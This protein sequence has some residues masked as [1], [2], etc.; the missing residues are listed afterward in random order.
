MSTYEELSLIVSVALL[1]VAIL[2]IHI[3][4]SRPAPWK[5]IRTAVSA[6]Y[7]SAGSGDMRSPSGSLV[8][9]IIP[10]I[11]KMSKAIHKL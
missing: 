5:R 8:K 1:I 4:N 3:R 10:N 11:P 7:F 6:K 9:Y 2:T